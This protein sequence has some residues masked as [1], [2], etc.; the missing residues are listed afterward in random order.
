MEF[1]IKMKKEVSVFLNVKKFVESGFKLVVFTSYKDQGLLKKD[2]TIG[3]INF[4]ID[5]VA[6][7]GY[8]VSLDYLMP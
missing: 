3:E 8:K 7:L 1:C 6:A 4:I 2:M 5:S